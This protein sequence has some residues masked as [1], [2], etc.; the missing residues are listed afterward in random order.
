MLN[1]KHMNFTCQTK[2][3]YTLRL[4]MKYMSNE[5]YIDRIT[6]YITPTG[7][8]CSHLLDDDSTISFHL[9]SEKFDTYALPNGKSFRVS[10]YPSRLY[11]I[12]KEIQRKDKVTL[13]IYSVQRILAIS[14]GTVTQ[15]LQIGE[16][17]YLTEE[18]TSSLSSVV[19][20]VTSLQTKTALRN[21]MSTSDFQNAVKLFDSSPELIVR[22]TIEG[23]VVCIFRS[24][25]TSIRVNMTSPEEKDRVSTKREYKVSDTD[26]WDYIKPLSEIASLT[27]DLLFCFDTN[28]SI[29]IPISPLG[30]LVLV[31]KHSEPDKESDSESEEE[32][33]SYHTTPIPKDVQTPPDSPKENE[34]DGCVLM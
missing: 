10:I 32:R 7:I 17:K 12:L 33:D 9:L 28:L 23:K 5:D 11:S 4:L 27:K 34:D 16:T 21:I 30:N 15:K 6:L 26:W 24:E 25:Y 3:P 18:E 14:Y 29:I 13:S 31:C 19:N 1:D 22:G 2:S 20:N 8:Y